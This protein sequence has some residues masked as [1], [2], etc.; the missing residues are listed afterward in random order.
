MATAPREGRTAPSEA[1][2]WA[3]MLDN[4]ADCQHSTP[5]PFPLSVWPG[6]GLVRNIQPAP[7]PKA[8]KP[9]GRRVEPCAGLERDGI[10]LWRTARQ[11]VPKADEVCRLCGRTRAQVRIP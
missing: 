8:R 4:L 9:R 6:L 5:W 1:R 10:H 7:A 11:G 2:S 3:A